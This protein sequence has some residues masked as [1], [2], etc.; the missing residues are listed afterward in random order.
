MKHYILMMMYL[1]IV[2]YR[3]LSSRDISYW[4]HAMS[5]L[6]TLLVRQKDVRMWFS[7]RKCSVSGIRLR[8]L[9]VTGDPWR[10]DPFDYYRLISQKN[11]VAL[12]LWS[13]FLPPPSM[14][15]LFSFK[16]NFY[17][18]FILKL[19]HFFRKIF[20]EVTLVLIKVKNKLELL[21]HLCFLFLWD[22]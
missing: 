15:Y 13:F 21:L 17:I 3:Y 1:C 5:N 4:Y 10:K 12:I 11:T 16:I 22:L 2:M 8:S 18:L 19:W 7:T 14:T 9:N 20:S 6:Y